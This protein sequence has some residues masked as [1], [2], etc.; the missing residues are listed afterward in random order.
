PNTVA[1]A[2]TD[3]A[4]AGWLISEGRRGTRVA[5]K[6]PATDRR[7]RSNALADAAARFVESLRHRGYS[8]TEIAAELRRVLGT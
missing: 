1:R 2:Y 5:S 8:P 4:D 3:L 7:A 6:T